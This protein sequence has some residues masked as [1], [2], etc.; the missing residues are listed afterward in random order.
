MTKKKKA[1]SLTSQRRETPRTNLDDTNKRLREENAQLKNELENAL[2]KT[3]HENRIYFSDQHQ[4][5]T[6]KLKREIEYLKI[7][8]NLQPKLPHEIIHMLSDL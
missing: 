1:Y 8:F 2:K 5:E 7:T 3:K 4:K 6:E